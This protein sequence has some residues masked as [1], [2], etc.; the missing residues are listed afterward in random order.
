MSVQPPKI[1]D[2]THDE[3]VRRVEELVQKYSA[4][5]PP[6]GKAGWVPRTDG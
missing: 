2:L 5:E 3:I 1:S 6:D 4:A